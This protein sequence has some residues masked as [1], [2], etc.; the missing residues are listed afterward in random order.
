[1]F[2]AVAVGQELRSES[3]GGVAAEKDAL[4][5][6][7]GAFDVAAEIQGGSVSEAEGCGA[8]ACEVFGQEVTGDDCAVA[9][10]AVAGDEGGG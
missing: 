6:S 1:M 8:G 5:A 2:D 3:R 4:D 9:E 7:G 10:G